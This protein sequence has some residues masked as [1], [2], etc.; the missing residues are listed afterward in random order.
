[1]RIVA[2]GA[3]TTSSE[4]KAYTTAS[5]A[6][7]PAAASTW[8]AAAS[9]SAHVDTSGY[10]TPIGQGIALVSSGD[11]TIADGNLVAT[12]ADGDGGQILLRAKGTID[13]RKPLRANGVGAA[14]DGGVIEVHGGALE[15]D[16]DMSVKGGATGGRIDLVAR[17]RL[18]VGTASSEAVMLEAD[19][20]SSNPGTGGEVSLRSDGHD[21]TIA[22]FGRLRATG[23]S[24]GDGGTIVVEGVGVNAASGADRS[25]TEA[26]AAA[27]RSR[28]TRAA[29]R[30]V[31][32]RS[33]RRRR[34]GAHL[35]LHDDAL[36]VA[37]R[38]RRR[39]RGGIRAPGRRRARRAVR[40]RHPTRSGGDLR[41]A[42]RR[43][44]DVRH[45]GVRGRRPAL[46]RDVLRVRHQ[47]VH[48]LSA[49]MRARTAIAA[50]LLVAGLSSPLFARRAGTPV[51][52]TV[53][54]TDQDGVA[55]EVPFQG[56][57]RGTEL[58]GIL[59]PSSGEL[60]V[61]ARVSPDGSVAGTIA[62]PDGQHVG[63]FAGRLD[64]A[65]KLQASYTVPGGG[66]GAL[67]APADALAERARPSTV[68]KPGGSAP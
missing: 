41:H 31:G 57:I 65:G 32:D 4:I 62:T 47:R 26:A 45:A 35:S 36:R 16:G 7:A 10:K 60:R 1:V 59:Q 18:D 46:Q 67:S 54:W 15:I 39:G 8:P 9:R 68:G 43:H 5:A 51:T 30:P 34:R 66:T 28:S 20:N 23:G 63:E 17:T 13:D 49:T 42:G 52:T 12:T 2:G 38:H 27:A 19:V 61:E 22:Q 29:A 3:V 56:T 25:R 21:V 24:G 50:G 48:E 64:D 53:T 58:R 37:A 14:S 44:A 40:R 11:I 6:P 33:R 55:G